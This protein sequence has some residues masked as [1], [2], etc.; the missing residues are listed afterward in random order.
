M[1]EKSITLT[2]RKFDGSDEDYEAVVNISNACNPE[3]LGTVE[4]WK[5]SDSNQNP[6][7]MRERLVAVIDEEIIGFAVYG[8]AH[9]SHQKG[10]YFINVSVHPD[11]R[12]LGVGS[13]LYEETLQQLEK[14]GEITALASSTR[15]HQ[16]DGIRFLEKR[17]FERVI[18]EPISR[19]DV[20]SFDPTPFADTL[21][22]VENSPINIYTPAE[23]QERDPN[24]W[25]KLYELDWELMQDVPSPEPFVKQAYEDFIRKFTDERVGFNPNAWFIAVAPS[26][27]D[28]VGD[29]VGLSQ[30]WVDFAMPQKLYTGLTGV[31]REYRRQGL[32]TAMK[33]RAIQFAKDYCA[34]QI[35]TDNEENNPMY[36]LNVMLG[37]REVTAFLGYEKEILS[38]NE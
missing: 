5:A 36:D 34:T 31:V 12:K 19:L 16:Q 24:C 15:E 33:V 25:Q 28:P 37:F 11:F 23:L 8:I 38:S 32:A 3:N 26:E 14:H 29:Y 6:E 17:N 30:L 20:A 18:R 9:W 13:R 22:R 7:H 2:T 10:K 1:T 27:D 21:Q 4:E 35:E